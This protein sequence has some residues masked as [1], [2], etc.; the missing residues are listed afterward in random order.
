MG[1]LPTRKTTRLA[2]HNYRGLQSYFLTLCCHRPEPFLAEQRTISCVLDVLAN[3]PVEHGFA[4]PAF[5]AMPDHLHFLAEGTRA[6]SDLLRF[7]KSYKIKT[8]RRFAREKNAK[9]WQHG[10]YEHV[11]RDP[12]SVEQIAWYIWL[13]PV[14]KGLVNTPQ[15]YRFSGSF[16]GLRMPK[17]WKECEWMPPWKLRRT[18]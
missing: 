7:V 1:D 12:T 17:A 2:S 13:N 18:D 4:I 15:E 10:Y 8:S 16:S 11:V 9:L 6:E 3:D 5:C 14:R